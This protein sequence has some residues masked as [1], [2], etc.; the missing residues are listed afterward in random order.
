[1]TFGGGREVRGG[2]RAG[3]GRGGV[4]GGG[5]NEVLFSSGAVVGAGRGSGGLDWVGIHEAGKEPLSLGLGDLRI[6]QGGSWVGAVGRSLLNIRLD[7]RKLGSCAVGG[8]A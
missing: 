1:M 6:G 5:W 8:Q 3:G 4:G 7:A 2:R